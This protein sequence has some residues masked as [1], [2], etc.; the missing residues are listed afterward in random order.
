MTTTSDQHDAD[1]PWQ[2]ID[3]A[4]IPPPEEAGFELVSTGPDGMRATL[5]CRTATVEGSH[6]LKTG[7][8]GRHTVLCDE[9]P[10]IG[11]EDAHP[12]PLAYIA[13]GMGFCLLTQLGRYASM[14][15]VT[16]RRAECDVELD[17]GASGS[18]L[19]GDVVA[20]CSG[21]RTVFRVESDADPA[22]LLEVI[23][24]AKRGCFGEA[25][26]REPVPLVSEVF[27]NGTRLDV[28]GIT[29]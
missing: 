27:V 17:L 24:L 5:R 6:M 2:D 28:E 26:I 3:V 4:K 20:S 23:R 21:A 25:M 19:R 9:G 10:A 13:L 15:K 8:F 29:G 22:A 16:Y 14:K 11:G 1:A 12:P 18:V 7:Q